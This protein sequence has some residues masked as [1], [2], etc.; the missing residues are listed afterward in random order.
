MIKRTPSC[1]AIY[2]TA[3]ATAVKILG[4]DL[5]PNGRAVSMYRDPS[6]CLPISPEWMGMLRYALLMSSLARK[7]P[8]PNDVIPL[9]PS[10]ISNMSLHQAHHRVRLNLSFRSDILWWDTFA[11]GWN[12]L[13]LMKPSGG[14]CVHVWI[15]ASDAFGS[16]ALMPAS[17]GWFQFKWPDSYLAEG[18]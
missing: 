17:Q 16:G 5:K 10:H 9:S 11:T 14:E 15:D 2:S 4:A 13:S 6:H 3:S 7:V 1:L 8:L 12:G 18:V